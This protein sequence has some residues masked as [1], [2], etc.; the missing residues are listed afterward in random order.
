MISL[1]DP[2]LGDKEKEAVAAV[3]DSGWLTM[4]ARVQE[5]EK[6]FARAHGMEDAVAVSSGT[7]GLHLALAG[8][9][10]GPGDE[11]LVPSLTFTATVNSILYVGATPVFV[12]ID[13][14]V[15]PHLSLRHAEQQRTRS[16]KAVIVMHYGGY[17]A[18]MAEWSKFAKDHGIWLIEDAAH[19]AGLGG[20]GVNSHAAAFSFFS[21]KNMTTAEGGM[22][23]SPSAELLSSVRNL[24]SHGMT[25]GTIERHQGRADSYDVTHLGYNYRMDEIRAALGLCQLSNLNTWNGER[26]E[27]SHYYRDRI[28]G[29]G[30]EL[31]VPFS[32]DHPT[33]GHLCTV[34]LP[35]DADRAV[36]M[37]R[38][39][40]SGVQTS[41]HYPPVHRFSYY[42]S[43]FPDISLPVTED[44]AQ[45]V[46]TLPLHPAMTIR[47]VDYVVDQLVTHVKCHA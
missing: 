35:A 40:D 18:D 2:V 24:R 9:G 33:A 38:M 27:L 20:V 13:G 3:I 39:R 1:S 37:K 25:T 45:R 17:L 5:F 29:S 44:F 6:A 30:S 26:R 12:D 19:T 8:L 23:V 15:V 36:I 41:I 43:R 21:N 11:I 47:D 14:P 31:I 16:T 42:R 22:V 7:A 10:L 32:H 34:L 46:L 28:T 4:G